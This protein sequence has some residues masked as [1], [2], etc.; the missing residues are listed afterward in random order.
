MRV[1]EKLDQGMIDVGFMYE[2]P[3]IRDVAVKEV[4][5]VPLVLVSDRDNVSLEHAIAEGYIRV[6][7]GTTF[8]SLHESHFPQRLLA[9]GPVNSSR[10]ALILPGLRWRRLPACRYSKPADRATAPVSNGSGTGD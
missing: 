4:A 10:I 5:S 9:R 6:E 7:W 8:A 3:R 2:P 1:V